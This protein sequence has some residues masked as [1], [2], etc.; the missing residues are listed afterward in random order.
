M[1]EYIK[2][3]KFIHDVS[4]EMAMSE[5]GAKWALKLLPEDLR[6]TEIGQSL[7]VSVKHASECVKKLKEYRIYIHELEKKL[8]E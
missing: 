3:R 5:G 6:S 1:T 4:N 2:H 8:S 7:E